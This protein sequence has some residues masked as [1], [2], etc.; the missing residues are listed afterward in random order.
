M[1]S[2][3]VSNSDGFTLIEVLISLA[4]MAIV[5][6]AVFKLHAQSLSMNAATRFHTTAALLLQTKLTE[7]TS[8]PLDELTSDS[9]DFAQPFA[10]YRWQAVI[11]DI[12]ADT[13]GPVSARLKKITITIMFATDQYR[14][15]LTTYHFFQDAG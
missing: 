8:T 3:S 5:L 11:E 1:K 13:L 7:I 10:G 9:G 6:V 14:Y 12:D 2:P 4:I 15:N